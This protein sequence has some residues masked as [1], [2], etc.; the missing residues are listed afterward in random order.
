VDHGTKFADDVQGCAV[1]AVRSLSSVVYPL[2]RCLCS[3]QRSKAALLVGLDDAGK[4]SILCALPEVRRQLR[5]FAEAHDIDEF[6]TAPTT[7]LQLIKVAMARGHR[8][9][10]RRRSIVRWDIWDMSGQGRY[11]PLWMYYCTL[12]QAIIYVIDVTDV[13]RAATA[14]DELKALFAHPATKGLPLL[15]LANKGDLSLRSLSHD[16]PIMTVESLRTLLNLDALQLQ[17]RLNIK[18]VE[19]SALTGK[20]IEPAFQWLT[21]AVAW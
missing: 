12:V 19:T 10:C 14:R 8:K 9:G 4:T 18:I 13:A 16:E 5:R 21:D 7:G 17:R 20:G 3:K 1:G 15:V 2:F 6:H 11:R